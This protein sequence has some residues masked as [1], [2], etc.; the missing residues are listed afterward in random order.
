M[1]NIEAYIQAQRKSGQTD[2]QIK[3]ALRAGGWTDIRLQQ[4]FPIVVPVSSGL[5]KPSKKLL[6]IFLILGLL[7]FEIG[8]SV[9]A[10]HYARSSKKMS[11]PNLTTM[12][13]IPS[14]Q[15][16]GNIIVA[17]VQSDP[18]PTRV[19]DNNLNLGVVRF[20]DLSTK[21]ELPPDPELSQAPKTLPSLGNWSPDGRYLPILFLGSANVSE[22]LYVYDATTKKVKKLTELSD[23][24]EFLGFST[25]FWF[26]SFWIDPTHVAVGINRG[27]SSSSSDTLLVVDTSGT[28][29][30]S[31]RP[32]TVILGTQRLTYEL[33]QTIGTASGVPEVAQTVTD[34]K[35]D[36]KQFQTSPQGTPFGLTGNQLVT[37]MIPTAQNPYAIAPDAKFTKQYEEATTEEERTRLM[38]DLLRPIQE[39]TVSLYDVAKGTLSGP[40]PISAQA[41]WYTASLQMRPQH[42]TIIVNQQDSVIPPYAYRFLEFNPSTKETRTIVQTSRYTA[43]PQLAMNTVDAEFTLSADGNWLLY[44][45]QTNNSA[46]PSTLYASIVAIHIDNGEKVLVCKDGCN[47]FKVYNP[48][49][50][51]RR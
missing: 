9:F 47:F 25:N 41:P 32:A 30:K 40:I 3:E 2:E 15:T 17:F 10:W 19:G 34:V 24:T 1:E 39:T 7:V 27:K 50:I 20:Y 33:N 8:S 35:I 16:T 23:T 43:I 26:Q 31:I 14:P 11:E 29:T 13:S 12:T 6:W 49:Q 22:S 37:A 5:A 28:V 51:V 38:N 48:D 45:E 36:G 44:Y 21:K 4:Y 42:N 18:T 46:F